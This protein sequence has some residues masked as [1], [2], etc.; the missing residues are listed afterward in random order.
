MF[1]RCSKHVFMPLRML[2]FARELVRTRCP[3]RF[4]L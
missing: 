2:S 3:H 4:G 1:G